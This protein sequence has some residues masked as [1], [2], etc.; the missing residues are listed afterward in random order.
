MKKKKKKKR[1]LDFIELNIERHLSKHDN[2][3]SIYTNI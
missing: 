2:R 3:V 1:V